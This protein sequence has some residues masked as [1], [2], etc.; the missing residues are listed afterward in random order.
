MN[1]SYD[2]SNDAGTTGATTD[3]YAWTTGAGVNFGSFTADFELGESFYENPFGFLSGND[4]QS[5]WG[6]ITATY[7][8]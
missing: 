5:T 6:N 3:G 7:N 1:W 4:D 2:L 8:F